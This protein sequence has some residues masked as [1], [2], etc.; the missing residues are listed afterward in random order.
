MAKSKKN[1]PSKL[2]DHVGYWM[3]LVSNNVSYSFARKLDA[4]GVTVAEWVI[5][6][7][8]YSK[9]DTTSPSEIAGI[10]NLSRGAISKLVTRLLDKKLVTRKESTGDRRYQDIELTGQGRA[11][12]PKLVKLADQNDEAFFSCLPAQD[13]RELKDLLQRVAAHHQ[14][15]TVPIE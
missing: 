11:L 15:K 6:R 8:M 1:E 5:L 9:S 13:R 10:T 14:I 2:T 3:R 7:E 4:S 12:V